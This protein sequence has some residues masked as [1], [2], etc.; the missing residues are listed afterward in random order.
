MPIDS[1]IKGG[2]YLLLVVFGI[3]VLLGL[4]AVY[5]NGVFIFGATMIE[6]YAV[7]L[8]SGGEM[9]FNPTGAAGY[10]LNDLCLQKCED[11]NSF[12]YSYSLLAVDCDSC[13]IQTQ[14][15]TVI[16]SRDDFFR[17]VSNRM[18]VFEN[19]T[20]RCYNMFNFTKCGF[21]QKLEDNS[22]ILYRL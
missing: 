3:H 9:T 13:V 8:V 4:Y 10:H 18:S 15:G 11:C 22:T 20:F 16:A 19:V 14:G 6:R 7:H 17:G 21:E 1:R 12:C 5:F 2:L